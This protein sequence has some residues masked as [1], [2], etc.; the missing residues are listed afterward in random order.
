MLEYV[1]Q[2][3]GFGF[4]A[5]NSPGSLMT[6]LISTTLSYGWR[7]GI[8]VV[9]SPL[10]T[11]API[12]IVMTFLL[13]GLPEAA[14]RG[15]QIAGGIYVLWLAWNGWLAWRKG[16]TITE[17]VVESVPASARATLIKA[18]GINLLNPNPYIFWSGVTG[19]IL[20]DALSISLWHGITFLAAFYGVFVFVMTAYVLVFDRLR[21][22]DPRITRGLLLL[23]LLV[24]A[25]LGIQLILFG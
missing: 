23:S 8:M 19:P 4:A 1:T 24:L 15:I 13:S 18:A 6:F 12:I 16:E 10:L 2:A 14:A 9:F 21:H 20:R 17:D 5:G 22:V 25:V 3:A 7:R 11:D